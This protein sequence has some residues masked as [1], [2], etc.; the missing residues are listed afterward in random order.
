MGVPPL[1]RGLTL[2]AEIATIGDEE[3]RAGADPP[4]SQHGAFDL[5]EFKEKSER[6]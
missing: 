1:G 4:C 5:D 3:V 2:E 6:I